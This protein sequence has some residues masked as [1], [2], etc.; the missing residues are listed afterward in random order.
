[1]ILEIPWEPVPLNSPFY[2]R[3]NH[4]EKLIYQEIDKGGSLIRIKSPQ[5]TGKTSLALRLLAYAQSISYY[6]V[7][8]DFQLAEENIFTSLDKLLLWF[9][10][11]VSQQLHIPFMVDEYYN[12]YV[13]AK[14]SC[15]IYFQEYLLKQVNT[16]VVLVFNQ[17]NRLFEYPNVAQDFLAM[18][19][20]W[21]EEAKHNDEFKQ[22]R[23]VL[24]YSTEIYINLNINQSPFNVGLPINLPEFTVEQ[25]QHLAQVHD[26]NWKDK[27]GRNNAFELNALVGGHP[28][29]VRLA[30]YDLAIYPSKSLNNLL[31]QAPTISGIYSAYLRGLLAQVI[32]NPELAVALQQ[33]I[34]NGGRARLNHIVV[35][36]LESLGIIKLN[37]LDATF[38]CN[39]YKK[40]FCSQNLEELNVWQYMKNLQQNN[41]YLGQLSNSDYITTLGNQ[42]FFET[43]LNQVWSMVAEK[44]VPISIILL[45]VDH[46]KIYSKHF[47]W[48][49]GNESFRQIAHIIDNVT[50]SF[51]TVGTFMIKTARL[52]GGEF[53]IL[54]PGRETLAAFEIAEIIRNEVFNLGISHDQN[55]IF[56]LAASVLTVSSGIACT[57]INDSVS[58]N[59]LIQAARDALYQSKRN[60]RNTTS[61]ST[62]LNG[63]FSE[64]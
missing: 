9:G 24:I 45:D 55:V 62:S 39:L 1:M 13:G 21:Y 42:R 7:N 37:D 46:L 5:K 6:T 10:A 4:V 32:K 31:E 47:G 59:I 35:H 49:A 43:S 23:F 22:F 15:T 27:L 38:S 28:Y 25:I 33:L 16:P 17:L 41:Q 8:L 36:K 51:Y 20:S 64:I 50:T 52:G 44:E 57:L 12:E 40:Y 30:L 26:L 19:R 61:V 53:G 63:E 11:N 34:N 58:P 56:G 3:H 29:L 48:E 60:G 54:L 14:V 2:I 18:L